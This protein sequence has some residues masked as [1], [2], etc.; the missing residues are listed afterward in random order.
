MISFS[1]SVKKDAN[2]KVISFTEQ[3][4]ADLIPEIAKLRIE[5]FPEYPFLYIGDY[6]YEKRYLKKFLTMKNA[7]V[8]CA[9]DNDVLIGISTG[10]PF[11]YEAQN[12]QELFRS[13]HRNPEEYFCFGESVLRKTYRGLGIGKQFFDHREVHVQKLNRYKHICFYTVLRPLH[14]PKRPPD[15]RAL[16]PFWNSRGFVEHPELIGTVSYQEI[17]ETDETPKKMVFWIK[18]LQI[19]ES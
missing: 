1:E 8:V 6:E 12:L 5:V 3:N 9:F 17:G 19:R 18:D 7:I 2:I 4:I 15:Y 13:A 11:I 10:Y 16:S 14:D